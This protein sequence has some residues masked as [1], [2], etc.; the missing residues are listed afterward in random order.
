MRAG[1]RLEQL[2]EQLGDGADGG[3]VPRPTRS[4]RWAASWRLI[5]RRAGRRGGA[6]R[7]V[8]SGGRSRRPPGGGS[9]RRGRRP[10]RRRRG[11][12]AEESPDGLVDGHGGLEVAGLHERP[13]RPGAGREGAC[14][15][16]GGGATEGASARVSAARAAPAAGCCTIAALAG[17]P[18]GAPSGTA[19]CAAFPSASGLVTNGLL[20]RRPW[21]RSPTTH[22]G[23]SF[24]ARLSEGSNPSTGSTGSESPPVCCTIAAPGPSA[25]AVNAPTAS[26]VELRRR[27]CRPSSCRRG[28]SPARR[29]RP[30]PPPAGAT[31]RTCAGGR[32][33]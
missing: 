33:S 18:P 20:I 27:P 32:S 11:P 23:F 26:R 12:G 3:V 25:A 31:A 13:E 14:R 1:R 21:V 9:A 19:S 15:A 4:G 10:A 7:R 22:C 2:P 29:G 16:F 17:A 5:S 30:T 28:P 6:A 24:A 8:G